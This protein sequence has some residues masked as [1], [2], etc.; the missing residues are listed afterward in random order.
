MKIVIKIY[1]F[2]QHIFMYHYKSVIPFEKKPEDTPMGIKRP[3]LCPRGS[4]QRPLYGGLS[5]ARHWCLLFRAGNL[6]KR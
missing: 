2:A 5:V 4:D 3:V 1:S 6:I